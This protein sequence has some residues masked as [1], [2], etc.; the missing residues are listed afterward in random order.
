MGLP[1]ASEHTGQRIS[2][3]VLNALN[4]ACAVDPG[5]RSRS[6]GRPSKIISWRGPARLVG[7]HNVQ[8][9]SNSCLDQPAITMLFALGAGRFSRRVLR[10]GDRA[11]SNALWVIAHIRALCGP[12]TRAFAAKRTATGD[13]R[14]EIMRMLQRYIAREQY[15]LIIDALRPTLAS[16][17][18]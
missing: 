17:L 12:R 4:S 11:A 3:R 13:S 14:R 6:G 18:T 1:T 16:G 7:A 10:G 9:R 2:I 15:P 8:A 5:R